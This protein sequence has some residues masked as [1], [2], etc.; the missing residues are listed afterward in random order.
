MLNASRPVVD[1]GITVTS[2][3]AWCVLQSDDRPA[4]DAACV[5]LCGAVKPELPLPARGDC[6]RRMPLRHVRAAALC[7]FPLVDPCLPQPPR[8][9]DE[10]AVRAA[11]DF[12]EPMAGDQA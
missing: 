7:E 8:G 3:N 11:G 1:R 2:C 12:A 10:G 5:R 6:V 9:G 4:S